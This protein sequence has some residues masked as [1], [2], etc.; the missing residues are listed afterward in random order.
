MKFVNSSRHSRRANSSDVI[1]VHPYHNALTIK[2]P[3][4]SSSKHKLKIENRRNK[5]N[6]ALLNNSN[7]S[8]S[9][10]ILA[11]SHND[12]LPSVSNE[13]EEGKHKS[14]KGN[15]SNTKI[16]QA[17]SFDSFPRSVLLQTVKRNESGSKKA[18]KTLLNGFHNSVKVKDENSMQKA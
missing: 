15:L 7:R 16:K 9:A 13:R 5:H 18:I 14:K 12:I 3:K 17:L 10:R 2:K 11:L 1:K 4:D 8:T 6:N